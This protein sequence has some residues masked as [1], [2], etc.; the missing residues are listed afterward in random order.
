MS[1]DRY[2]RG[3][4]FRSYEVTNEPGTSCPWRVK[5]LAD[6]V[7]VGGGQYQTAEQ[8][9]DAGVSYMFSGGVDD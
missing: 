7:E 2:R 4:V 6:G 1:M 8:A 5:F 3:V 9:D